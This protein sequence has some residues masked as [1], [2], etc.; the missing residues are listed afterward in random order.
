MDPGQLLLLR[1]LVGVSAAAPN[2]PGSRWP[3]FPCLGVRTRSV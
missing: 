3:R 1:W 2:G